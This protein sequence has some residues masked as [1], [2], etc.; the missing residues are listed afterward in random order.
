LLAALLTLALQ[1]LELRD[2]HREQLHDDA[3]GD[4]GHDPEREDRHLLQRTA[5]E[6]VDDADDVARRPP[7][8]AS[9]RMSTSTPGI[10]IQPPT[11]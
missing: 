11:R 10:G 8:I 6:H 7:P 2:H 9:R 5:G 1:L 4:V 3:G